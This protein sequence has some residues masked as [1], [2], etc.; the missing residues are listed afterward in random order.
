MPR[1]KHRKK[2]VRSRPSRSL[3]PSS[4][5]NPS[6]EDQRMSEVILEFIKPYQELAHGNS[7]LEKLIGLGVVA[8]NL[9]LLPGN[10]RE[11]ALN[12]LITDLFSSKSPI[13][14]L[15]NMIGKWIRVGQKGEAKR[16]SAEETEFKK[17]VY[18]M[19]EHK[20]RRFGRNRRFIV[21][22]H[23]ETAGEDVQLFV[24]ST[25]EGIETKRRRV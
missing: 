18:E 3:T 21:S 16:S 5:F 9:S 15:G 8:W 25:L 7:D 2:P 12:A 22:Y 13:K 6:V 4:Y 24:A 14:K 23:V 1:S 11:A 20:Q 10:E 17:I 19:V